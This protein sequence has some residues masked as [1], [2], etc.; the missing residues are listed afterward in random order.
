MRE[1]ENECYSMWSAQGIPVFPRG[2][3]GWRQGVWIGGPGLDP[4]CWLGGWLA[5][6]GGALGEL[7]NISHQRRGQLGVEV[8]SQYIFHAD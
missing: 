5:E 1:M 2:S 6:G 3:V 7:G 8:G 4:Y